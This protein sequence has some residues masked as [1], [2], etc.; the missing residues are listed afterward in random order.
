MSDTLAT[1]QRADIGTRDIVYVDAPCGAHLTTTAAAYRDDDGTIG[2]F[3]F[4][5]EVSK[6]TAAAY[7][8]ALIAALAVIAQVDGDTE[9]AYELLDLAQ[10]AGEIAADDTSGELVAL[11][12]AMATFGPNAAAAMAAAVAA[13][14]EVMA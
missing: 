13:V 10:R 8:V 12:N 1:F 7:R 5:P 3:S 11:K 2:F 9:Q 14:R 4:K 6:V